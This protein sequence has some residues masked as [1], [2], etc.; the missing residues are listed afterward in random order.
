[1]IEIRDGQISFYAPN[2]SHAILFARSIERAEKVSAQNQ[3][4]RAI[5]TQLETLLFVLY[6]INSTYNVHF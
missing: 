3:S 4:A 5:E 2:F 1:M 6:Y